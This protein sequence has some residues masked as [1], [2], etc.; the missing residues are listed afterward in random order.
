MTGK[1]LK[2]EGARPKPTDS[3]S[4]LFL[5]GERHSPPPAFVFQLLD[6]SKQR[7]QLWGGRTTTVAVRVC[8]QAGHP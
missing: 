2:N 5:C 6:S 7:V 1:T 3:K 8:S 4:N